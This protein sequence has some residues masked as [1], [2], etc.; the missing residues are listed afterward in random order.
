[1]NGASQRKFYQG[2]FA[3]NIKTTSPLRAN[4]PFT[5]NLTACNAIF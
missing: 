2:T 4:Q 5:D 3:C 1:M